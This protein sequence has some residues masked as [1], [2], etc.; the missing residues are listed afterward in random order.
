M[1]LSGAAIALFGLSIAGLR[2][3][4]ATPLDPTARNAEF[5]PSASVSIPLITPEVSVPQ[6][7]AKAVLNPPTQAAST[8]RL[9][10][11]PVQEPAEKRVAS[12][13]ARRPEAS[14]VSATTLAVRATLVTSDHVLV[15][16][17]VTKYQ[18]GLAAARTATPARFPAGSAAAVS[19][20]NRFVFRRNPPE[21][22]TAVDPAA[23]VPAGG[24]RPA[25]P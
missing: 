9:A 16:P 25:F 23:A 3:T 21:A 8:Q 13:A 15:S 20:I 6:P 4:A 2:A 11:Q 1:K 18:D 17:T 19:R 12:P 10:A 5:S 14:R 7:L 24:R 22:G